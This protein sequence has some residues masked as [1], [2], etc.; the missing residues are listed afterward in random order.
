MRNLELWL[1]RHGETT[2]NQIGR[3]A[4]WS[5]IPLNETGRKQAMSLRPLLEDESF[6]GV[7]ASDLVRTIDT[8]RLA[9]GEPKQEPHLREINFGDLE[10][11]CWNEIEDDVQQSVVD[12]DNFKA[13]GGEDMTGF[14]KRIDKFISSLLPGRH[15]LF[16]HGGVIRVLTG[17]LG[18][19]RFVSN[20]ALV[21]VDWT[22][23][24]IIF[25]QEIPK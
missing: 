9:Y 6:E 8:A 3:L 10:G 25:M 20:G 1:V 16:V 19:N 17:K 11:K 18:E 21:A 7:W 4:G 24:S 22:A 23:Q 14:A 13:P 5:D 12:F 15:L 2:W